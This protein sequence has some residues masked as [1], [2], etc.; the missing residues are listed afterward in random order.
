MP[1]LSA[2]TPMSK[3]CVLCDC[4][5]V[6]LKCAVVAL[7]GIVN[8]GEVKLPEPSVVMGVVE[9]LKVAVTVSP[10]AKPLPVKL[11]DE[12]AGVYQVLGV[13]WGLKPDRPMSTVAEAPLVAPVKTK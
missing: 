2:A 12:P 6:K 13:I 5:L 4:E 9:E 11:T 10:G 7:N 1:G 3:V 8:E